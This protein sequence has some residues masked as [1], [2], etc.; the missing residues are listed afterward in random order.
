[1]QLDN[2]KILVTGA[3]GFIGSHLT[4]ALVKHGHRVSVFVQYNSNSDRGWIDTF[5]KEIQDSI[6]VFWGDLKDAESVRRAVKSHD[7]VFHLAALIAVPYSFVNPSDVIHTNAIGTMNVLDACRE[8]GVKKIVHTSTSETYGTAITVP[9][10][11]THP[12][13][14]QS[15]Y[16]AS[17]IAADKIAES[18]HLA[19]GLPVATLRPFNTYGPRQ[20]ARAIIPTIISQALTQ[21]TISLGSLEPTRDLLFVL[22]TVHGFI[23]CAEADATVGEVTNIGTGAEVSMGELAKKILGILTMEKEIVT[24]PS[25]IRPGKSEVER[26]LCDNR[27]ANELM[28]WT[29]TYS[30]D[31]GLKITVEWMQKN[32]ERYKPTM[33]NI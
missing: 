31:D 10:A 22:D 23:K 1:M 16:A 27:K 20:S 12:S 28:S 11:E 24:D 8:Y 14:A 32:I 6:T 18:Y 5:P 3:S 19:F 9:I 17:K 29:P 7:V 25:R 33:Y 30:L 21:P 26:L 4:E 13:Q 15:P 2:Q